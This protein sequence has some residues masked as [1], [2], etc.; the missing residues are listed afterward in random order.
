MYEEMSQINIKVMRTWA[1]LFVCLFA[2][3]VVAAGCKHSGSEQR[4]TS[5][6]GQQGGRCSQQDDHQD[7]RVRCCE[8]RIERK[9]RR[10]KGGGMNRET[11]GCTERWENI[12]KTEKR[13]KRSWRKERRNSTGGIRTN[14][15]CGEVLLK[16]RNEKRLRR[17]KWEGG[18]MGWK[19]ENKE[20]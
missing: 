2:C 6:N 14:K 1:C 17:V 9:G 15:E 3:C 7:E 16:M 10:R 8:W 19:Q 4:R 20:D 18:K 12:R 11:E 5:A 13:G